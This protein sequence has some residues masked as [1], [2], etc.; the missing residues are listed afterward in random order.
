M[1][2]FPGIFTGLLLLT[3]L[4]A[5]SCHKEETTPVQSAGTAIF[6]FDHKVE[7]APL[8]ENQM[9][10]TNT[11]GNPYLISGVKYFISDVT[12]WKN[13]GSITVVNDWQDIF[14]I[15]VDISSTTSFQIYDPIPAGDYD[16]VTFIFGITEEKNKSFMFVNP[17][18]VNMAWPDVLGGGYHY[19]MIDGKW[20]DLSGLSQPFNFH[21]GIG[22]LYHGDDYDTDSIYA[23][24][25]NY[26]KVSLPGSAFSISDKDT[27]NFNITMNIESWFESPYVFDFNIWGGAIMQNQAAMEIAKENGYN[28]FIVQISR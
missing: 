4:L 21:L 15:D 27:L 16:S 25:Q 1:A 3:A 19:M 7:G 26:F 13:D 14:Y 12:F 10:Y 6:N 20:K 18:E 23:F 2:K 9:I 28:V 8:T 22:Q 17:P 11:A 5:T 24:V